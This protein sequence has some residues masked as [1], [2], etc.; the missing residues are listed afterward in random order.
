[1][2]LK[3][4]SLF[5]LFFISLSLQGRPA[6]VSNLKNY[7]TELKKLETGIHNLESTLG[8]KN[9]RYIDL[10]E[11]RKFLEGKTTELQLEILERARSLKDEIS[12][13][14]KTLARNVVHGLNKK[15]DSSSMLAAIVLKKHLEK[16]LRHYQSELN[17]IED[18]Q[19]K[20]QLIEKKIEEY[21]AIETS[22]LALISDLEQR[23]IEE[24]TEYR[25]KELQYKS[26]NLK[27]KKLRPKKSRFN[28]AG[29]RSPLDRYRR[30]VKA[31][32][33]VDL[34]F[35]GELPLKATKAGVVRYVGNLSTFGNVVMINHGNDTHSTLTGP[36]KSY[37]KKGDKVVAGQIIGQTESNGT[38]LNSITFGIW[39]K[40]RAQNTSK[41]FKKRI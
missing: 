11:K 38:K 41:I 8:K 21:Y 31:R 7:K 10:I 16:K 40:N 17:A 19:E 25:A 39:Y 30:L 24:V 32:K 4:Y 13:I 27:K 37:V 26:L 15:G 3:K 14:K 28:S 2:D 35:K 1:M 6:P 9:K 22:L 34:R 18:L 5:F 23:K 33:G 36:F 12:K 29:F 20:T